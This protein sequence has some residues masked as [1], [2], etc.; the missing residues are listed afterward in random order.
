MT[1]RFAHAALLVAV[2]AAAARGQAATDP[3][4]L[5]NGVW[6]G[7]LQQAEMDSIRISMLVQH[8]DKHI[9]MT[10][11]GRSGVTYDM[12]GARVKNDVLTFDWALGLGSFFFCR[13]TRRDGKSFEGTCNDRNPGETGKPLRVWMIIT[14]PDS[15]GGGD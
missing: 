6:R 11:Q 9:L 1:T 4:D 2:L 10:M 13:M 12:A 14:P 7:W 8:R 5:P 15:G 3:N